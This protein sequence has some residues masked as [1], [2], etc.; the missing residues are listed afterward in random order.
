[1][2][3]LGTAN[4]IFC[5]NGS[6]Q[7]NPD[8][9]QSDDVDGAV[10]QKRA[11]RSAGRGR[12]ERREGL[13]AGEAEDA[14]GGCHHG[15]AQRARFGRDQLHGHLRSIMRY[16]YVQVNMVKGCLSSFVVLST[17]DQVYFNSRVFLRMQE[18]GVVYCHHR[19]FS[20]ETHEIRSRR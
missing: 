16:S 5:L 10:H 8:K 13:G 14:V 18:L 1:M 9:G 2:N 7:P 12:D 11:A 20:R 3:T 19:G 17:F 15:H 6:W 4:R